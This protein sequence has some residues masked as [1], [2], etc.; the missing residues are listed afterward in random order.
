M[1]LILGIETSCDET[2]AAVVRDVSEVCSSIVASQDDTHAP[3]GGVVPELAARTHVERID[4]IICDALYAAGCTLGDLDAV[5]V[6]VG[7]GLVG[8]L[9]VGIAA[10]KGICVATGLPFVGVNHLQAHIV[11]NSVENPSFEPPAVVLLVSGGHT[12]LA[13]MNGPDVD[14]VP[15]VLGETVDDAVGEAFDKV[16]RFLGLGYPGGPVIDAMAMDGDPAAV[17]LPRAMLNDGYDFSFSGLKT[18]VVQAVRRAEHSGT[19]LLDVDVAAS[20]QDCV[21]D[22]LVTKTLRAVEETGVRKVALAGGVASNTHLRT[23]LELAAIERDV[24]L[25]VPSVG[26]CSD[27]AAMVAAAADARVRAGEHDSLAMS[28]SPALRLDACM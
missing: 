8:A 12:L 5:A 15:E 13:H 10:A 24:E 2:A 7:P 28:A 11:A 14:C 17:P 27:N 26:L 1:P 18:A 4:T 6:T 25:F 23:V 20:F 22:I 9:L 21:V 3:F 16:A 19:P